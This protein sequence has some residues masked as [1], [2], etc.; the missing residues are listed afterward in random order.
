[1]K[2]LYKVLLLLIAFPFLHGCLDDPEG[3]D[4]ILNAKVP[5]VKIDTITDKT[6]TSFKVTAEITAKNGAPVTS[7]GFIYKEQGS[8]TEKTEEVG[9]GNKETT[10]SLVIENLK[11]NTKYEIRAYATNLKGTG[12]S[13]VD[14]VST[15]N[16]LGVVS[17]SEPEEVKA[18]TA[19]LGGKIMDPGE[20][21]I[22]RRGVR[23]AENEEMTELEEVTFDGTG[24]PF[25]QQVKGLKPSTKYYVKAFV[26]NTFGIFEGT[27]KTFTT[28]DGKPILAEFYSVKTDF[29]S[30]TFT[31]EVLDAGDSPIIEWGFCWAR[32][33]TEELNKLDHATVP[34][35]VTDGGAGEFVGEITEKLEDHT[36]YYVRAYAENSFGITYSE[37]ISFYPRS[38]VPTVTT[39][40]IEN[41]KDGYA[42]LGMELAASGNSS[43]V[44]MGILYSTDLSSLSLENEACE[45][46]E[47]PQ[48]FIHVGDIFKETIGPLAG[49]TTYY[50]TAYAINEAGS[51]YG[52]TISFTPPPVFSTKASYPVKASYVTGFTS[53][54]DFAFM[55]GGFAG[56]ETLDAF[57]GYNAQ[58]NSWS[59]YGSFPIPIRGTTVAALE[60]GSYFFALGGLGQDNTVL[61]SMYVYDYNRKYWSDDGEILTDPLF[62]AASFA[63]DDTIYFIGGKIDNK[64]RPTYSNKIYSY[65]FGGIKPE[66]A[67]FGG[68]LSQ[69]VV[70]KHDGK[71]YVGLGD[72]EPNLWW[73]S[74][75]NYM[76]AWTR[77]E[78]NSIPSNIGDITTGV[79]SRDSFFGINRQ[80]RLWEYDIKGN[81]W[82]QRG[83]LA[84]VSGS[85]NEFH[86]FLLNDEIY[87]LGLGQNENWTTFVT[88]DPLWDPEGRER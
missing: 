8:E 84:G 46:L 42:T 35:D 17:T 76:S 29:H 24:D 40:E 34:V 78:N 19:I 56:G 36:R 80:G 73:S 81:K 72:N 41:L 88:Y 51:V 32:E 18:T 55:L 30:I 70:F 20:G 69:G 61:K 62:D 79:V 9:S 63:E 5:E 6:A 48:G 27:L 75:G 54:T 37:V 3:P 71:V 45:N 77:V 60:N 22:K 83:V 52:D 10:F 13:D 65:R 39:Y 28:T 1:M 25:S 85:Q 49:G 87:I 11:E 31:A 16:G 82:Y 7:Y 12:V 44:A 86:M 2:H 4:D 53:G 66:S 59:R 74:A 64:S 15:E 57:Y 26:E 38:H 68:N 67:N 58:T 23:Y 14:Q 21:E 50:V 47:Y 43:V 33:A